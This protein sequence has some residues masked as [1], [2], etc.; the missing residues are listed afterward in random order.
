MTASSELYEILDTLH[1][2]LSADPERLEALEIVTGTA[3][4]LEAEEREGS[5]WCD[6]EMDEESAWRC[7]PRD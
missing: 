7:P 2:S 4:A 3:E 6:A 1:A 5:A